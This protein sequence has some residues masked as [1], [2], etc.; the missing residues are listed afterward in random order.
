M[1]R[2]MKRILVTLTLATALALATAA[3]AQAACAV[4][5]KAKRDNPLELFHE[6]AMVNGPC[7]RKT[8]RAQLRPI[9]SGKGLTLLKILSIREQ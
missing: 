4:E 1:V 6:T 2:A 8:V 7:D 5:Y 9:L 3:G